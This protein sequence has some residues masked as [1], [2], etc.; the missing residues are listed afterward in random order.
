M[1]M[2]FFSSQKWREKSIMKLF[3]SKEKVRK[4][5]V[6]KLCMQRDVPFKVTSGQDP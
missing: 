3:V 4:E 2:Y 1:R 6:R 5:R